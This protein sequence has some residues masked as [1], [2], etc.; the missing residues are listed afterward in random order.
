MLLSPHIEKFLIV[1]TKWPSDK[2]RNAD[3][4]INSSDTVWFRERYQV[5]KVKI[6]IEK[7]PLDEFC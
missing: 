1:I 3:Y 4:Y 5:R 7:R 2:P 6:F